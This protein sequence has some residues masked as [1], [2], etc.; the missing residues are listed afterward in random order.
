MPFASVYPTSP[1]LNRP[2][3]L[4]AGRGT[5]PVL[6]AREALAQGADLRL[7]AFDGETEPRLVD[8]FPQAQRSVQKVGQ[9]SKFLKTLK[10]WQVAD[11]MMAGQITP[12]KLFRGLQPDLKA[13][14]L[15]AALPEKNAES[16][17]GA[18]AQEVEAQGVRLLD[19]RC[20]LQDHLA[21]PGLMTGQA[22]RD[23]ATLSLG[24]RAALGISQMDIGQ[25]VAL[26]QG[27][28]LA[29]EAFEGTDKMLER[30]GSFKAPDT[31]LVK[32][33]KPG[34]DTRFDVPVFGLRTLES[35][36][37]AGIRAAALAVGTLMLDKPAVL[38][39]A[40]KQRCTLLGFDPQA[41]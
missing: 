32:T 37:A 6:L 36:H 9:L 28:V 11:L 14:R 30:A 20:F 8:Q 27:T 23:E 13:V 24:I 17:F 7:I 34:Q 15:L 40:S 4:V 41:V 38:E 39:Q 21:R 22:W 12:G 33:V 2:L 19:A 26:S 5:Y 16:L 29:V 18:I 31:L 3:C 35:M 10:R 25:S 1:N